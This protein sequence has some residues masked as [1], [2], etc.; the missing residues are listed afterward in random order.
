MLEIERKF[1]VT[2]GEIPVSF[3]E[4][5]IIQVGLTPSQPEIS[6][7]RVRS[8]WVRGEAPTY[9]HT[10]KIRQVAGIHEEDERTIDAE[11]FAKLLHRAEPS[12]IPIRKRRQV[13]EWGGRVF[14][15][16]RFRKPFRGLVILEIE[17][18]SMEEDIQLPPF[19]T[20]EREVTTEFSNT[21]LARGLW[22][23]RSG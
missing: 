23:R 13:F 21:L 7:E 18:A 8:R 20:I 15:L 1:L 3:E 14:E 9:T 12:M 5:E 16:D 6:S 17:L 2:A 22:P 10:K 11:T 4:S 19:L